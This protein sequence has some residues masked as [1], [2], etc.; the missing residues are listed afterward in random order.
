MLCGILKTLIIILILSSG[1]VFADF[2]PPSHPLFDSDAVHEIH[3][4]FYSVDWW[5]LLEE[6]YPD[7]TYL[8][9][10]FDWED[11]HFDSIGV[12]FKGGSSYV[13]N[14]TMKKSFKL[15]FDLFVEDQEFFGLSK[16]NL[17][18]NFHDPSFV[19]ERCCYEICDEAGLPTVRS[20]FVALY[21]NDIYWGLYTVVEQYNSNFIED[22]FG[23]GENG[24]LWK[25][26]EHGSLEY[27]GQYQDIYYSEFELK[28][29]E[30]ENDWSALIGLTYDL[31]N[32]PY[33]YMPD[34]LSQIMDLNT[35]LA[36]L[37]VDNLTVNLDSYAGRCCNY[38]L[39]QRERDN[40][41][42]FSNWDLNEAWGIFNSWELSIS[43]R[44]TLDPF[45]LSL[46]PC[47]YR[48]LGS[49]LWD[50]EEYAAV[51]TGHIR[52][53]MAGIAH[54]DTLIMRMEE[55]RDLIRDHVYAEQHPMRLFTPEEFENAMTVDIPIGPG[56]GVIP[57]LE[58]FIRSRHDYLVGVLG[59]WNPVNGLVLNEL[60]AKNDTTISDN[61]GEF[62]DW[63]EITNTGMDDI[64]LKGF[65]LTDN[66]AE[67]FKFAFPDTII[68]PGDHFIIWADDDPEQGSM[69]ADFKLDADGEEVYLLD[70]AIVIDE[71]TFPE[72]DADKSYGLWPDGTGEWEI[73]SIATPGETNEGGTG[74]TRP[75]TGCADEELQILLPNPLSSTEVVTLQGN[76]GYAKLDVFDLSGRLVCTP[77][78]GYLC[79]TESFPW[80][81]ISLSTGVYFLRLS[82]GE[83]MYI[84]RVTIIR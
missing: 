71:V 70:S 13:G 7:R 37:A 5:E 53:L 4:Y 51:Y 40:L 29:N 79:N 67:P 66:M 33:E 58:T 64:N 20:N 77:F 25:G 49:I 3:L 56:P 21:I 57:A 54:Q 43:E 78:E 9:A 76:E 24:N 16:I 32:T 23:S 41:F 39:Y 80:D 55:L 38:Y 44:Q 6:N 75:P 1:T 12:R 83:K 84:R 65:F 14:P 74:M 81:V 46:T 30:E 17:N 62:D 34:T 59:V 47:E 73:L 68:Q 61:Y 31:N 82:Q 63:I 22:H 69:H 2:N 8:E 52:R 50:F 11:T 42:V 48:P 26:D 60:M 19:R 18:C 27:L 72:L 10:S 28:T 36:L 35:A 45:W 15:D